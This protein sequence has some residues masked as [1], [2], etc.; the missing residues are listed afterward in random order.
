MESVHGHEGDEGSEAEDIEIV[1]DLL[2]SD[3]VVIGGAVGDLVRARMEIKHDTAS[4]QQ[5]VIIFLTKD[6]YCSQG[7]V[8]CGK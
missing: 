4:M 5:V 1:A 7:W 2:E 8:L 3:D 6:V